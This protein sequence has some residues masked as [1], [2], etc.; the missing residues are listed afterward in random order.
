MNCHR[1]KKLVFVSAKLFS[2]DKF[3]IKYYLNP[4]LGERN[5]WEKS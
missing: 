3:S 1:M 2:V 4:I 5:D